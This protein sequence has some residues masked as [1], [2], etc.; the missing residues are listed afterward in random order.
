M[1]AK[2]QGQAMN[3]RH[4]NRRAFLTGAGT[5]AVGLPFLESLPSRSA[6]AA[7]ATPVFTFFS[8]IRAFATTALLG[9]LTV[10][11]TVAV[12]N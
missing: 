4:L 1:N 7:D 10:P 11:S 9:S 8:T 6:W 12:S 5:V 2:G 3:R